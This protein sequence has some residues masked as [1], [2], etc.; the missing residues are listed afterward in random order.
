MCKLF[1]LFADID[2]NH[3]G[4]MTREEIHQW[5]ER[6]REKAIEDQ[7]KADWSA[8]NTNGDDVVIW[9][10]YKVGVVQSEHDI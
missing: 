7:L 8:F 2:G 5:I 4:S 3:D 9:E 10:E 6:I 1:R